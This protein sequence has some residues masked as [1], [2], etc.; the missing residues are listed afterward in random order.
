[1]KIGSDKK[2]T[3]MVFYL[4]AAR[5]IIEY[6][7]SQGTVDYTTVYTREITE[8]ALLCRACG[9]ILAHNHPSGCG[10]PS[11]EDLHLTRHLEDTLKRLN[12]EL[13]DHVIVTCNEVKSF[14]DAVSRQPP[15]AFVAGDSHGTA[16]AKKQ[17]TQ[18]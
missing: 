11:P 10:D 4:D 8:R 9:V 16:G 7:I 18:S 5:H 2:E 14:I 1:M 12:I 13:L 15:L 6:D 3:L 17:S